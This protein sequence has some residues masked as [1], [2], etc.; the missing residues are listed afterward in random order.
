[1]LVTKCATLN[2]GVGI[3][4]AR[5]HRRSSEHGRHDH[6]AKSPP[7][8]R[9]RA[10]PGHT[11]PFRSCARLEHCFG[12]HGEVCAWDVA[13][14]ATHIGYLTPHIRP[15]CFLLALPCL[16][17]P[18]LALPCLALPCLALPCLAFHIYPPTLNQRL[19]SIICCFLKTVYQAVEPSLLCVYGYC[20]F[21]FWC[22]QAR[23]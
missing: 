8:R 6:Y 13:W 20:C 7:D 17:L 14:K 18:C 10:H 23:R 1:M 5:P 4:L 3:L 21:I 11:W 9:P 22:V 19:Y 2:A 12:S 15:G 16:A